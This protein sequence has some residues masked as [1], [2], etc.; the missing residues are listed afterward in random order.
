[1]LVKWIVCAVA[2]AMKNQFSL[3]QEQW[4]VIAGLE[5]FLGQVGGWALATTPQPCL[6][7]LWRDLESYGAFMTGRHE[8]ITRHNAQASTYDAITTSLFDVVLEMPGRSSGLRQALGSC[9]ILRTADCTVR[10]G[11]EDHFVEVQCSLW[12]PAMGQTEGMLGGVFGRSRAPDNRY[13]ITTL[14]TDRAAHEAYVASVL[15]RLRSRALVEQDLTKLEGRVVA[16]ERRWQVLPHL[17][18]DTASA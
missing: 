2:E 9:G 5:G 14:W 8:T 17:A 7:A 12:A 11:R 15:P 6:L 18:G 1:M 13:L 4:G 3:A 16:L 10:A